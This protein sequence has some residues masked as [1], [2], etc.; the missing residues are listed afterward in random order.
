MSA[1]KKLGAR[2]DEY[3]Q[4]FHELVMIL[5]FP[6]VPMDQ[7]YY[8]LN[9]LHETTR[10]AVW[11]RQP[12]TLENAIDYAMDYEKSHAGH[13]KQVRMSLPSSTAPM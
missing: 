11:Y 9:G 1:L 3:V 4:R 10:E 12:R 7:V 5:E 2:F 8:F 13:S 6:P